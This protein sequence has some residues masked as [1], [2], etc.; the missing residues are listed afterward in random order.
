MTIRLTM[1][2]AQAILADV[3]RHRDDVSAEML[4]SLLHDLARK[5]CAPLE[6]NNGLTINYWEGS[7]GLVVP[8]DRTAVAFE[9]LLNVIHRS[10]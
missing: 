4:D 8:Q 2:Q 5:S 6:L 10:V 3:Y 9:F 7:F 1:P